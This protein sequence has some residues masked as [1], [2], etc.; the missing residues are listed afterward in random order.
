M[1]TMNTINL[2]LVISE[3]Y[4]VNKKNVEKISNIFQILLKYNNHSYNNDNII[5]LTFPI[6]ILQK[7]INFDFLKHKLKFIKNYDYIL[8]IKQCFY[9][10]KPIKINEFLRINIELK[11]FHYMLDGLVFVVYSYFYNIKKTKKLIM[12]SYFILKKRK[13][14]AMT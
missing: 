12:K 13:Q 7:F 1:N 11:N 10:Y 6:I 9:Y 2:S 3:K 14:I 4:F 5:P 8:H